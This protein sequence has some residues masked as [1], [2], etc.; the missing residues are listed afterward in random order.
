MEWI[1]AWETLKESKVGREIWSENATS[2]THL[3]LSEKLAVG[4]QPE[5]AD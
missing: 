3:L 2:F 5:P 1:I 4:E